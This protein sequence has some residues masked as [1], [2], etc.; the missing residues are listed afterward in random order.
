LLQQSNEKAQLPYQ[1]AESSSLFEPIT[2]V[3][4]R[5]IEDDYVDF[6]YERNLP[7]MLSRQGPH[8]AKGDVN[9]DG[10]DDLYIG[11]AKN[12]PRQLYLQVNDGSFVKKE[13]AILKQYQDFEDIAVLFFDADG[14]KDLD[15]FIGAG[16]NNVQRGNREIQH[17][18]YI[19][20]GSGNFAINTKAFPN[21]DMNISV[22]AANDYDGDGDEDLFVGSR[23]VPYSYGVSPQSYIYQ[24]NGRGIFTDV[25]NTLNKNIAWC[26]MITSATWADVT[27]DVKKEL[28]ITGEWMETKI[29]SCNANKFQEVKNTGL[30]NLHGWWQS[31]ASA[32]VNGDGK[33]DLIIGNIGENFYLRPA[34]DKPT[35][36]WVTDFDR[37][38]TMDQFLTQTIGGK[39]MPVFLKREITDQ[40]PSLKKDNL[41]H[42]DYAKKTI[43]GLFPANVLSEAGVKTFNYCSSIVAINN[44]NGTFAVKRLP[45]RVQL[46]SINAICPADINGDGKPDLLTG[47]N[48]F[49]FPPQ[50]GRLDASY[51]DVLINNG[52]GDFSPLQNALSGI[53]IRDEVKDIKEVN[54]KGE[55][56]FLFTQNNGNPVLYRTNKQK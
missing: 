11:G 21:N 28:I 35:K 50:F 1:L 29:Y 13:Q 54:V 55:S 32:D 37:N 38:G 31:L 17:R 41:K 49:S 25:T 4:D 53:N 16:G 34:A 14:D 52:N 12:Q 45:T 33:Q 46:S 42:S 36:L 23:S 51:G 30:E 22:V 19:N 26:G 43:Q 56:R 39:D 48:L 44:G 24:N 15:L 27:G 7:E 2:T 3:F 18:L 5:H 40:F 8:I 6:Y 47:G 9:G 10:L 20:D